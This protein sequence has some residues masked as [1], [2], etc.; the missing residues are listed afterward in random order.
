MKLSELIKMLFLV[1]IWIQKRV[2]WIIR[3]HQ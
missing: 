3:R 2:L 1:K